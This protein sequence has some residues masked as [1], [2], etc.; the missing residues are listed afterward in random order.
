ME[1]ELILYDCILNGN[2]EFCQ[3]KSPARAFENFK[4]R[5]LAK[6]GFWKIKDLGIW[7]KGKHIPIRYRE[8]N[9]QYF[10]L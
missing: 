10:S 2:H 5:G 6:Q 7:E 1:K 3:S 8:V 9:G 4:R